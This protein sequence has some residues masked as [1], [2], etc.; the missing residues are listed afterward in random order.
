MQIKII[1]VPYDSG[2]YNIR[3]GVGPGVLAPSLVNV[4]QEK[5]HEVTA[6]ELRLSSSFNTE[7]TSSFEL[8]RAVAQAVNE[9]RDTALPIILSGNCNAAIGAVAGVRKELDG[10]FW[11]D[12]HADFN[13]PESST[14]GFFDGM[15]LAT[16]SG[17]CWKSLANSVPGFSPM[18]ED[19][20]VLIGARDIDPSEQERINASGISV[21]APN[22]IDGFQPTLRAKSIYVHV[23][24]DVLDPSHVKANSYSVSGGIT[25]DQLAAS[26]K[27]LSDQY[28]IKA[29]TFA[30][31]HP[32]VDVDGRMHSVVNRIV[33]EIVSGDNK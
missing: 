2:H 31:Y 10:I 18:P 4:L 1:V 11:F 13:T 25:P 30:S 8:N 22:S 15:T 3:M 16:I 9:V 20:I 23:D 27:I 12:C 32:A 14:S 6:Q 28:D 19:Q 29:I 17:H 26:I 33:M 7:V 24:L 5:G 21:I